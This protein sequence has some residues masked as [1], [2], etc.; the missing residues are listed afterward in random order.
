MKRVFLIALCALLVI[1]TTACGNKQVDDGGNT[2]YTDEENKNPTYAADPV[3]NRFFVDF[4]NKYSGKMLD[5]QSIRR[6]AGN[7]N[8]KPEDLTKE[9]EAVINGCDITLRNATYET[10]ND[11]GEKLTMYQLRIIIQGGTTDKS[12][13]NLMHTFSLIAPVA[14]ADA[15]ASEIENAVDAMEKMT[16]TDACRVSTYLKV[17]SYTP[18]IKEYGVPCKIEMVA[19]NYVPLDAE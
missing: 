15:S 19:Y 11:K 5:A 7:A 17:E 16:A 3:I 10:E 4:V 9:Y 8:T 18:I 14:D 13:D 6:G 12:R 2:S 1:G